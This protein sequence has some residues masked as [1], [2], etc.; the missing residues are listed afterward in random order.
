MNL[1]NPRSMGI[2]RQNPAFPMAQ[3]RGNRNTGM[4][5]Y[6]QPTEVVGGYDA[7]INPMTGQ[8]IPEVN[9]AGGG[10]ASLVASPYRDSDVMQVKM[11]PEKWRGCS[12]LRCLTGLCRRTCTTR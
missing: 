1:N 10:L 2:P 8:E 11:T 9:F 7:N 5:N 3:L 12:N 6:N 4:Y